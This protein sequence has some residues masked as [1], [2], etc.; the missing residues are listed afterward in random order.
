M[1]Q[2]SRNALVV[3]FLLIV[4]GGP[5]AAFADDPGFALRFDGTS[6]FVRLAA[7]A[8]MMAPTW[9]TTKTVTVWVNPTGAAS[10]TAADPSSCDAIFGDKPRSWGISRGTTGGVDRLWVFNYDG[11]VGRVGIEYTP[12]EWIQVAL[13][14]GSG[15]LSAY[16]NGVLVGS[17]PSGATVQSSGQT[18]QVGGIISNSSKNWTF[19]GDVDEVRIWNTA[20]SAAEILQ[21]M[22]TTL[23]GGEDGLAAYYKMSNGSGTVLADDSGHGWTGTLYDGGS[24][25]PA[26]GPIAWVSSGALGGSGS[27]GN[28]P[29][30]ADSQTPTTVEDLALPITLTGSDADGDPLTFAV[31]TQPSRGTLSGTAPNLVYTP[32]P[33]ANGLDNFT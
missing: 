18:L 14:H 24:G 29:P 22:N 12:G 33:N 5:R 21:D 3:T 13:V 19:Q 8:S 26:D 9:P 32:L 31:V 23:T 28:T 4:I 6:D 2:Q 15:T 25:V 16:K 1:M 7:T 20:R 30:T 27:T 10:C 11:N 17:V